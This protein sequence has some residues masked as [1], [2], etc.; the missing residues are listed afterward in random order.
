MGFEVDFPDELLDVF[1]HQFKDITPEIL[2]EASPILLEST[3]SALRQSIQHPGDS[4]LVNSVVEGEPKVFE[5]AAIISCY[6]KGNSKQE[7]HTYNRGKRKY[8]VSN[9]AKAFW[10]EYGVAGRQPARPWQDKAT[11]GRADEI[12]QKMQE[13]LNEIM[14]AE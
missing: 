4:E 6:P 9:G 12:N 14:G 5:D 11:N 7:V 2:K 3:K 10:L 1:G 8:P 13:K